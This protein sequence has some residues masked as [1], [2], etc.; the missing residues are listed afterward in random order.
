M[1]LL[2]LMRNV[3]HKMGILQDVYQPYDICTGMDALVNYLKLNA[4]PFA[5]ALWFMFPFFWATLLYGVIYLAICKLRLSEPGKCIFSFVCCTLCSVVGF[6]YV[7]KEFFLNSFSD[8]ALVG[9][10]GP[11]LVRMILKYMS[12]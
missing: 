1:V 9:V 10:S 4:E 2:G 12:K 11:I 7:G 3:F 5:G 6:F 8:I